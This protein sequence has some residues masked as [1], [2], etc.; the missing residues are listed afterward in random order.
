MPEWHPMAQT[1]KTLTM[2]TDFIVQ[3]WQEKQCRHTVNMK[4]AVGQNK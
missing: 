3:M 2:Y 4:N 1:R